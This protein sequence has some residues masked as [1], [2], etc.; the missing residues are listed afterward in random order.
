MNDL[1]MSLIAGEATD[2]VIR[3]DVTVAGDAS[4]SISAGTSVD[5]NSRKM[6]AGE[7]DVAE[8]SFATFLRARE[9]GNDLIGLPVFTGRGFLQPGLIVS[10]SSRISGPEDLVGRRVGLPQFWMTSSVWHRGILEQQHGVRAQDVE[11]YTAVEERFDGVSL[12]AGVAVHRLPEGVTVE[13]ALESGLVEAIMVP[14]RGVPRPL[15][16][17][18]RSPYSDLVDAERSY[19]EATGVFPIMHFVVMR[20]SLR[21][22][23]PWL[24]DALIAAFREAGFAGNPWAFGLDA[25]ARVLE[26]FLDFAREQ[27]WISN[28]LKLAHCFV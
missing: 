9:Q 2:P 6:L 24:A 12:P 3:G 4:W 16:T 14:P 27:G 15:K 28:A 10:A 26:T 5:Q 17:F 21:E 22:R 13:R 19:F 8:M 7:F 18:M 25:N 20:E 23:L 11:W 1:T